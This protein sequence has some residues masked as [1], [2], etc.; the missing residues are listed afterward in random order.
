MNQFTCGA[1]VCAGLLAASMAFT[2]PAP[3]ATPD[4][5]PGGCNAPASWFSG[6]SVP[7]PDPGNAAQFNSNCAF[8]Q[9]S[10]QSFLWLT[11]VAAPGKL[12]FETL[13]SDRAIVPGAPRPREHVLGG[14]NQANS[15]GI[16]V[17]Q[18]GR[19]VY[20]AMMIDDVYRNFVIKNQLYTAEGM[21]KA[22]AGMVFPNGALSLK[23][24]WKIVAPGED[25]SRFYTTDATIEL[26]SKVDGGVGIDANPKTA[27]A[28][29]ALVG[30]H[31]AVV[32]AGHPEAIW[33]T[34]EHVDNAP[35]FGADQRPSDVVSEHS[36][37]FYKGGTIAADCNAN[38]ASIIEL[39]A[40]TQ[41]LSPPTQACRQ[42]RTGA[43]DLSN[44]NNIDSLNHSVLS[45]LA[46]RSPWKNYREV[47][48]V[49]F[50]GKN[51]LVPDWTPNVDPNPMTGSTLLSSAVIETFTQNTTS[52]N[53]C[54]SCHNT[55]AVTDT[56]D[57]TRTL[58]GKNI[59]TS[60]ILLQKYLNVATVKR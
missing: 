57:I 60:H 36:Y 56:N 45:Q 1:G 41:I 27:R 9:F 12:R 11:Q 49:W 38:N 8:H 40:R 33:A 24:T 46:P 28:K 4:P 44:V 16:L 43:G 13:Y 55:M 58:S 6:R 10:W 29:V 42:Y 14:V 59:N 53:G 52:E 50:K 34:F 48:A 2:R 51:K 3:A 18:N 25:A 37:T 35:D 5:A 22:D 20:T 21:Q 47:G 26:L 30:L 17:D 54:F 32:V 7:K 15:H 39:D 23:S 19:A 31:V